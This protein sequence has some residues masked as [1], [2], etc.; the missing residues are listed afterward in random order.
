MMKRSGVLL[1]VDADMADAVHHAV[2]RQKVP[3]GDKLFAR[4][5]H[6]SRAGARS[7]TTAPISYD[8]EVRRPQRPVQAD[9]QPPPASKEIILA[10]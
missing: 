7:P 8:P 1:I 3:G 6:A 4:R 2:F 5:S 10:I 9:P